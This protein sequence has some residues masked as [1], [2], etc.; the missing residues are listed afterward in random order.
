MFGVLCV[1]WV[2]HQSPSSVSPTQ[3]P[4]PQKSATQLAEELQA[5]AKDEA[6]F[7]KTAS[8]ARALKASLRDPASLEWE[9]I[10]ASDDAGVVCIEYRARNGFGGMNRGIL[11]YAKNKARTD[12][13]AWN[14]HCT[15]PLK[16]MKFVR[17]A[18]T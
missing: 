2:T 17:F 13:A 18:V 3:E 9:T 14:A 8:V 15:A 4:P 11:V 12:A 6:A 7:Q 10:R 1:I 5:K 16:D